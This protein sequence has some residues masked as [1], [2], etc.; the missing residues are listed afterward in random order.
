MPNNCA[1]AAD[2]SSPAADT[3]WVVEP[4]AATR[5]AP[6]A[7]PITVK[8]AAAAANDPGVAITN[9]DISGPHHDEAFLARR[10]KLPT[11]QIV[12]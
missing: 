7:S 12:D 1:I 9:D 4:A 10:K 3:T 5:A 11:V 2:T 6:I 8:S